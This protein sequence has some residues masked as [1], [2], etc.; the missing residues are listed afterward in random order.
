MAVDSVPDCSDGFLF[1]RVLVVW[2]FF[3]FVWIFVVVVIFHFLISFSFP[4][5][6]TVLAV[7]CNLHDVT[8]SEM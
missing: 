5:E 2:G 6:T 7:G 4:C 8:I 3:C 1:A